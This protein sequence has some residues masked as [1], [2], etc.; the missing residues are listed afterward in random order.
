MPAKSINQQKYFG[1]LLQKVRDGKYDELNEEDKKVVDNMGEERIKH[2][3]A[4]KWD[5]LP[6]VAEPMIREEYIPFLNMMLEKRAYSL[7]DFPVEKWRDEIERYVNSENRFLSKGLGTLDFKTFNKESK[8][9]IGQIPYK[10]N[11]TEFVIPI[12]VDSGELK[13]VDIIISDGKIYP[14]D[15]NFIFNE[16]HKKE[17]DGEIMQRTYNMDDNWDALHHG[18]F[19]ARS[20]VF[21]SKIAKEVKDISSKYELPEEILETIYKTASKEY[22]ALP[23]DMIEKED[24]NN[25]YHYNVSI[26]KKAGQTMLFDKKYVNAHELNTIRKEIEKNAGEMYN[27]Q[28]QSLKNSYIGDDKRLEDVPVVKGVTSTGYYNCIPFDGSVIG[29]HIYKTHPIFE[30]SSGLIVLNDRYSDGEFDKNKHKYEIKG[31]NG[32]HGKNVKSFIYGKEILASCKE[33]S[34][35][36]NCLYISRCEIQDKSDL[37]GENIVFNKDKKEDD[38]WLSNP[39]NVI[40]D[41]TYYLDSNKHKA[42]ILR[43]RSI[44]NGLTCLVW[45]NTDVKEITKANREK[46]K[47]LGLYNLIINNDD[48]YVIPSEYGISIIGERYNQDND[49]SFYSKIIEDISKDYDSKMSVERCENDDY[50][51]KLMDKKANYREYNHL[52]NSEA[53]MLTRHYL[54]SKTDDI[55]SIKTASYYMISGDIDFSK[56]ETL[57]E[58]ANKNKGEYIKAA[59]FFYKYMPMYKEA[60]ITDAVNSLIGVEYIDDVDSENLSEIKIDLMKTLNKVGNILLMSRLGKLKLNENVSKKTMNSLTAL[61]NNLTGKNKYNG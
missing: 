20:G 30:N 28:A 43:L 14:L 40:Q 37:Q 29:G 6:K 10:N 52:S 25:P 44:E 35:R 26:M 50:S 55:N 58:K 54:G 11:G 12:I 41:N 49:V 8:D 45:I 4:T 51:I 18:M 1:M 13:D 21:T 31:D 34:R 60:E 56:K 47:E 46:I 27:T 17:G 3:A 16:L 48:L 38:V 32:G 9:A 23:I 59:S 19:E 15:E 57:I 24:K 7:N 5:G 2:Y 42:R 36:D 22:T 61:I 33:D 39:Y 53:L